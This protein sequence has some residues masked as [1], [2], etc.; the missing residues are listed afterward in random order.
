MKNRKEEINES[1]NTINKINNLFNP[2]IINISND[3]SIKIEQ[4]DFEPIKIS[5]EKKGKNNVKIQIKNN[6]LIPKV[7]I[8]KIRN[9]LKSN[10]S[11]NFFVILILL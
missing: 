6:I 2:D 3:N 10:N 5:E 1:N 8:N 7:I 11:L 4:T 9:E